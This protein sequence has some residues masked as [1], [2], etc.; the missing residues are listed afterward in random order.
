MQK[1]N[2]YH[3]KTPRKFRQDNILSQELLQKL[4]QSKLENKQ[5]NG[6]FDKHKQIFGAKKVKQISRSIGGGSQSY[7]EIVQQ[8]LNLFNLNKEARA[9]DIS[10][11]KSNEEIKSTQKKSCHVSHVSQI[12]A[13]RNRTDSNSLT[14]RKV[15]VNDFILNASAFLK[16]KQL[17]N[18]LDKLSY[19]IVQL[20]S[21]SDQLEIQNKM[22]FANLEQYQQ[23]NHKMKD[24]HSLIKKLDT[25][26]VMQQRQEENLNYFKQLFKDK[27]N[28]NKKTQQQNSFPKLRPAG[29]SAYFGLKI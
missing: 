9:E 5:E 12:W 15:G 18:Q 23:D 22:L 16:E 4:T 1:S 17:E 3:I 11:R 21:K 7:R 28:E 25:M 27:S 10:I 20:Q 8:N 6:Y 14:P 24:R 2:S 13:K 29:L 19:Q 26:I